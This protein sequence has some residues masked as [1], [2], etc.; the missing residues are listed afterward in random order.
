MNKFWSVLIVAVI[1][2]S[3][4]SPKL[5][6]G[7]PTLKNPKAV[8][9]EVI[10]NSNTAE[11]IQIKATGNYEMAG[12]K[13]S[14]KADIRIIRDSVIWIE[15]SDPVLGIKA[16]RGILMRDS[17]AFVNK[18]ERTYMAGSVDHFSEMLR[19]YIDFDIIQNLLLGEP[20]REVTGKDKMHVELLEKLYGLYIMPKEDPLFLHTLPN[21][22]LEIEPT[23]FKVLKQEAVDGVRRINATYEGYQASGDNLFPG[24]L[25]MVLAFDNVI[26][27]QLKYLTIKTGDP[28]RVPFS[29]NSKYKRVN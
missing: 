27:L 23:T 13:Q 10:K 20:M 19:T 15:L 18:I 24:S 12:N 3:C 21:Y 26:T 16:G 4:K 17:I 28:V 11:F 6:P 25:K 1:A 5:V 14:F 9:T 22:Y 8:A 29:I 2:V 7:T